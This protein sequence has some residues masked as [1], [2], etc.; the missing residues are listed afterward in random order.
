MQQEQEFQVSGKHRKQ[1]RL[2]N[3][4]RGY[5]HPVGT[6]FPVPVFHTNPGS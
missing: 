6:A 2:D 5:I 1:E 3:P 4:L